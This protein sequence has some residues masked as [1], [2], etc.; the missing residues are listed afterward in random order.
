[1]N[2][3]LIYLSYIFFL[4]LFSIFLFQLK[5]KLNRLKSINKNT[6]ELEQFPREKFLLSSSCNN[7][8]DEDA[9]SNNSNSSID[10]NKKS[11]GVGINPPSL[12]EQQLTNALS[13]ARTPS[14]QLVNIKDKETIPMFQM[15]SLEAEKNFINTQTTTEFFSS[16]ELKL[17]K[18]FEQ[19]VSWIMGEDGE[20]FV[21]TETFSRFTDAL[22]LLDVLKEFNVPSVVSFLA[23][24]DEPI[25]LT[26]S[27]TKIGLDCLMFCLF[28]A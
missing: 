25:A 18:K 10:S 4:I 28:Q 23:R 22:I 11:G 19:Q 6:F 7:I 5:T 26:Y 17:R 8:E 15:D 21:S 13:N 14:G 16:D 24:R 12:T 9:N 3:S 1:M 2:C 27:K 20:E